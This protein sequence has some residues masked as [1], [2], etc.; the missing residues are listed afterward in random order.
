VE[1]PDCPVSSLPTKPLQGSLG[2]T[3][4]NPVFPDGVTAEEIFSTDFDSDE[5][6]RGREGRLYVWLLETL[7]SD[8]PCLFL[9]DSNDL[10]FGGDS[11]CPYSSVYEMLESKFGL[12]QIPHAYGNE[13]VVY[14]DLPGWHVVVVNRP[15]SIAGD[16][17]LFISLLRRVRRARSATVL[18]NLVRLLKGREPLDAHCPDDEFENPINGILSSMTLQA[19]YHMRG[20]IPAVFYRESLSPKETMALV[21][22]NIPSSTAPVLPFPNSFV[23]VAASFCFAPSLTPIL[24]AKMMSI[25]PWNSVP[26]SARRRK[27]MCRACLKNSTFALSEGPS[28]LAVF[29]RA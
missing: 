18:L 29:G 16:S 7:T 6:E 26:S 12:I 27:V 23:L 9:L 13:L 15:F 8:Q 1:R 2:D 4:R 28:T 19:G 20:V 22:N 21:Q 25:F 14:C 11:L 24:G 3:L 17:R 5:K 10:L